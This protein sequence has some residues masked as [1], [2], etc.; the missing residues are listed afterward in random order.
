MQG[1]A[2]SLDSRANGL[3]I[4]TV[5]PAETVGH[6]HRDCGVCGRGCLECASGVLGVAAGAGVTL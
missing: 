5:A 2:M 6:G 4:H 3:L 1:Q